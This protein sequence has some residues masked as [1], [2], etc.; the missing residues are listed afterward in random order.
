M[1]IPQTKRYSI[2]KKLV[3]QDKRSKKLNFKPDGR[4]HY[5]YRITDYTRTEKEHY[6]GSHTPQK[7]KK[8]STLKEEFWTY[9]TSS[10]YNVLNE[11]KKEDYKVKILKVFDNS[12]DKI[13]Y[14]AF[15]HQY[16][17][18]KLSSKFWNE[19]NQTPF[20]FDNTGFT[21]A[22]DK[23]GNIVNVLTEA[24]YSND[25]YKGIFTDKINVKD[26]EGNIIC[27]SSKEYKLNKEKYSTINSGMTMVRNSSNEIIRVTVDEYRSNNSFRHINTGMVAVKDKHGNN[28]QIS[29]KDDKYILGE[30]TSVHKG[31]VSVCDENDKFYSVSVNDPRYLSGELKYRS[32]GMTTIV[33]NNKNIYVKINELSKYG[34]KNKDYYMEGKDKTIATNGKEN[35]ILNINDPK[36]LSGE[37]YS[38]NKGKCVYYDILTKKFVRINKNDKTDNHLG[39][40]TRVIVLRDDNKVFIKIKDIKCDDTIIEINVSKNK[41][42]KDTINLITENK[43]YERKPNRRL[44][45]K[46]P[47][48][49]LKR[50]INNK[51]Y[52]ILP[53][54]GKQQ[55]K[56]LKLNYFE[57]YKGK[58][59]KA[60]SRL[61]NSGKEKMIGLFIEDVDKSTIDL[62]NIP[63]I[64]KDEILQHI[65]NFGI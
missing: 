26:K 48:Y 29:N 43:S 17:D 51:I 49:S 63:F 6:Y 60:R 30:L 16:F 24:F 38:I 18:V 27:I 20:G 45:E 41:I 54:V 31:K 13:I 11:D 62:K 22:I 40:N 10:E 25:E 36:Y 56:D 19:S 4:E 42:S 2:Y 39:A 52:T 59:S 53:F 33:V 1:K 3:L 44:F 61:I 50:I 57:K 12:G 32:V 14:E 34:I 7:N 8:Y 47:I 64:H 65:N 35:K 15:L 21:P 55:I 37:F 58:N 23:N 9:R 46:N 28:F 5:V